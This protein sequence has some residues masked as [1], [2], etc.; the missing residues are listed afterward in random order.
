MT[1]FKVYAFG[2]IRMLLL[3][4]NGLKAERTNST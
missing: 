2:S 1:T 3:V 4:F